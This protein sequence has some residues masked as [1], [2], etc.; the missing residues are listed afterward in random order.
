MGT[1]DQT[2]VAVYQRLILEEPPGLQVGQ[3]K[4]DHFDEPRWVRDA[5]GEIG[6]Q[7]SVA[8][9]DRQAVQSQ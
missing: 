2:A 3:A 7:A 6:S 4:L 9:F 8:D 1:I 5:G